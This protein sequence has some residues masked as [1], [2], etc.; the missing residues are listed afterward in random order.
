MKK[1][2]LLI[3]SLFYASTL[4]ALTVEIEGFRYQLLGTDAIVLNTTS[5]NTADIPVIPSEVEYNGLTYVVT[6][7]GTDAFY[8]KEFSSIQLPNSIKS[9]GDGA[10][11]YCYNLTSIIIPENV[12]SF[13]RVG[14]NNFTFENCPLLRTVVY[15]PTTAP[16]D[17]T[18]ASLTY[19][20]DLQ[21]YSDPY[22]SINNASIIEMITWNVNEFQYTGNS[23][24][25]PSYVNNV[26][27]YEVTFNTGDV[28]LEKNV[29][30]WSTYIPATFMSENGSFD[31]KI[32][33]RYTIKQVPLTV[34][35][36]NAT[37][38]YGEENPAFK[39]SYSGFVGNDNESMLSSLP[40]ART[41]ATP[42]SKVG[43][44]TILLSG[45]VSPNYSIQY[46]PGILTVAKA[47]L[48]AKVNDAR[49][50]YGSLNPSFAMEYIG[51]KNN[52]TEP[53]WSIKPIF[54]TSATQASPVGEYAVSVTDATPENYE[55]SVITPGTLT[56]SPAELIITAKNTN[57]RYYDANPEFGYYCTGFV[58]GDNILSLSKTPTMSTT[59]TLSSNV[60]T[61]EIKITSGSSLN[62]SISYK[63]G[64]LTILPRTLYA[65][66][67]NYTRAYNEDNPEFKVRYDGFV[68]NDTEQVLLTKAVAT[69]TATK[70]SNVGTY[71]IA[72][73]GGSA[74][75]YTLSYTFGTLTINK[76]EQEIS[77]NQNLSNLKVGDQVE[78]TATATSGLSV[79]YTMDVG[80]MAELYNVGTKIY[81]D[82][83][84]AGSFQIRATQAG[85]S[86]YYSTARLVKN[87]II[88]ESSSIN[89][90]IDSELKVIK[91]S[92]GI[93]I[94]NAKMGD[95]VKVYSLNGVLIM[96]VLVDSEDIRIAL[97]AGAYI[98]KTSGKVSKVFL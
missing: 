72:V 83:K 24:S 48:S 23:P 77:W 36:E 78:L 51:L 25:L 40:M 65:T 30:T 73:S 54:K 47:P 29:G 31:V 60:G 66:V 11:F 94:Q 58:N 90:V 42:Q 84:K 20:P 93:R 85:N 34:K 13:E 37:R 10:F 46:E 15:L 6:E 81:L 39:I 59:A 86:N 44:Y 91:T 32:P 95:N 49:K 18:A 63:T 79:T 4:L 12:E 22:S 5:D 75:N 45:A 62:Y 57:R 71:E 1:L 74:D 97:N 96:S 64:T 61:Y 19:V 50:T 9:I 28:E 43:D 14:S 88:K 89:S 69:T 98:V 7:I 52:E 3:V 2:S 35:V 17:W 41:S 27:G 56:I 21:E 67:D 68:G 87:V 55:L 8:G 76:A 26:A 16:T 53:S 70:I 33:F 92:N 38:L 82:C 80:D